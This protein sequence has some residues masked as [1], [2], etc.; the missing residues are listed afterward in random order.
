MNKRAVL[1]VAVASLAPCAV[2]YAEQIGEVATAFQLLGPNHKIVV[3]AY[4][5]PLVAGVACHVSHAVAGGLSSV[6]GLSTDKSEASIACRQLGPLA[7]HGKLP[8]E[9]DVFS[10]KL[11]PLFKTLRVVR[12]VDIKRNALVYL[13]YSA[14]L[15]DGSPKNSV[16]T[17]P[18]PVSQ[19]I[20]VE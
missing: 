10:E 18:V 17:V 14:G 16:T 2:A 3:E 19:P 13:T 12:M 11:S 20:P 8:R 7:F 1:F 6:V 15:L 9:Q 4:D 5:D